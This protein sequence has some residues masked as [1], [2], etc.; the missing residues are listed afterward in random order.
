MS[1]FAPKT[2]AEKLG[3]ALRKAYAK[4][5]K[6]ALS[7]LRELSNPD[8]SWSPSLEN[9]LAALVYS[10]FSLGI[11]S[12]METTLR[13]RIMSGFRATPFLPKEIAGLFGSRFV[14]YSC[15]WFFT[16]HLEG[17]VELGKIFARHTY[18]DGDVMVVIQAIT[19]F[20]AA[21]DFVEQQ[22]AKRIKT[23]K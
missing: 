14:E 12:G 7:K 6:H 23:L 20:Q 11:S 8:F 3:R 22:I 17:M 16:D 1:L 9:E 18:H 15:V 4:M 5:H 21:H 2:T 13:D 10:A 19:F